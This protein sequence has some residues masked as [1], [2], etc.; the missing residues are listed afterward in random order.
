ME[1]T[2]ISGDNGLA[3]RKNLTKKQVISKMT[4]AMRDGE[5]IVFNSFD[6][7]FKLEV[8]VK[9]YNGWG[10]PEEAIATLSLMR[11]ESYGLEYD[12]E[13][14]K[15]RYYTSFNYEW[16]AEDLY[17]KIFDITH[18]CSKKEYQTASKWVE[19]RLKKI[20]RS[21]ITY[22]PDTE[23]FSIDTGIEDDENWPSYDRDRLWRKFVWG[24]GDAYYNFNSCFTEV[25]VCYL[26]DQEEDWEY[27]CAD[28][29]TGDEGVSVFFEDI[30]EE[31]PE[32]FVWLGI[33]DREAFIA[34][35]KERQA[36]ESLFKS[37]S[38]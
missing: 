23:K 25:V 38:S 4:K 9:T 24:F 36:E 11:E 30:E 17:E 26:P 19:K 10:Y 27:Y 3:T 12:C 1:Q 35:C 29:C 28:C 32:C 16:D 31:W 6:C 15:T 33:T 20:V 22:A 5:E 18:R 21:E 7:I 37:Q 34:E 8:E 2:I 14:G 13:I